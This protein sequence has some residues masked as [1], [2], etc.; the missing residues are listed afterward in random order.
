MGAV[1]I[2]RAL[3]IEFAG[4]VQL[5]T[6]R[7]REGQSTVTVIGFWATNCASPIRL[8]LKRWIEQE[9]IK[10]EAT[11]KCTRFCQSISSTFSN[12][13]Y[14]RCAIWVKYYIPTIAT[15]KGTPFKMAPSNGNKYNNYNRNR[16]KETHQKVLKPVKKECA[17]DWKRIVI[18]L[19]ATTNGWVKLYQD[20]NIYTGTEPPELFLTW[21]IN[22]NNNVSSD[23]MTTSNCNNNNNN[24]G[25]SD[26]MA[27]SNCNN[28]NNNNNRNRSK[29]TQ[30]RILTVLKKE[31]AEGP[32]GVQESMVKWLEEAD[33]QIIPGYERRRKAVPRI[34]NLHGCVK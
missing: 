29:E 5:Q 22:S 19:S 25:S 33:H 27:T 13:I 8:L 15:K 16:L 26:K 23:K 18:N 28:N 31:S 4:I 7:V 34:R 30:Q 6:T 14:K 1:L 20:F 24:N 32:D 2:I 10:S 17:S 11:F 21:W 12:V 9:R 3:A